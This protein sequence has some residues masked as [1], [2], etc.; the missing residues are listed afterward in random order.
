MTD[1]KPRPKAT[2]TRSVPAADPRR[3]FWDDG[4][5]RVVHRAPRPAPPPKPR[6]EPKR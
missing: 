4:D 1:E 2:P 6:K 5:L 3:F